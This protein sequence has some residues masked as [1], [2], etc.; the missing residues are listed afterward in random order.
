MPMKITLNGKE[1]KLD[2]S[3]TI[4]QLLADLGFAGKPVVV[5]HNKDAI[6]PRDYGEILVHNQDLLE[7]ISIAAGG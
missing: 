2:K 6:F 3:I 1:L 5:E 7:I 4:E